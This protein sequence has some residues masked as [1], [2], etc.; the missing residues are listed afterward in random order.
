MD[1]DGDR[2][3]VPLLVTLNECDSDTDVDRDGVKLHVRLHD[4]ACDADAVCELVG[5]RV[6]LEDA[7]S[8]R[9]TGKEGDLESDGLT[10][11]ECDSDSCCDSELLLDVEI[12]LVA[13]RVSVKDMFGVCDFHDPDTCGLTDAVPRE[14]VLSRVPEWVRD[15][16]SVLES[17]RLAS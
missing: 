7:V 14:A 17:E 4:F 16:E 13:I 12:V 2:E 8:D 3:N 6:I 1:T 11:D 15:M 9:V 10:L 5:L